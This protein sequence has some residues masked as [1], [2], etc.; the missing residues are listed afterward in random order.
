MHCN[1]GAAWLLLRV[2]PKGVTTVYM[3]NGKGLYAL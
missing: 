3:Q 2:N 1:K